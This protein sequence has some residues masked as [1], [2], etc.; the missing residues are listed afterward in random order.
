M[1]T[2]RVPFNGRNF[3]YYS[4]DGV[5]SASA[6]ANVVKGATDNGIMCFMKHFAIN[7]RETGCRSQLFTWVSEAGH[8][9]IYL[10][11][12]EAAVKG[13]RHPGRHELFQLH[14]HH[15]GRRQLPLC[16]GSAPRRV[17]L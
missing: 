2:H 11:P 13:G 4:E 15:L 14:R 5:L 9:W 7:D 12:F 8:A 17:G 3:E 16:S 1:N 10:R 6:A